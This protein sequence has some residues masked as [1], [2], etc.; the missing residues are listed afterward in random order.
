[1]TSSSA[2]MMPRTDKGRKE[3]GTDILVGRAKKKVDGGVVE[4][5]AM[6]FFSKTLR[7]SNPITNGVSTRGIRTPE[8]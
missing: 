8:A 4:G 1:M 3:F 6:W 2:W 7:S 5:M